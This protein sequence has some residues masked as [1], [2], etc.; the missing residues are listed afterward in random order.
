[1]RPVQA[2]EHDAVGA[3]T[4][5]VYRQAGWSYPDYEPHLR[6]ATSRAQTA[7]VLVALAGQR[8]T[9]AVTV[10]T[11]LGP[12][13]EQAVRGEAI[14][15]MLVVAPDQRGAGIGEA[16]VR[17]T[18]E[19]ARA[20]GCAMVRLSSRPDMTAAHRLYERLGFTRTP[21]FDWTPH[22]GVQ[23]LGYALALVPWCARCGEGLTPDGH[24]RCRDA[25]ELEPPR[26]CA[27]CRRR[28][29]VQVTPSGWTARCVE[30]GTTTS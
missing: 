1:M 24:Q 10:A 15:R 23:L 19:V 13:A 25:V 18:V 16:L 5:E 14:V 7:S 22:D 27:H 30:H 20:D 26:Y 4:V 3:L 6:D 21:S 28:H 2:R 29:V 9:G 17:A 8:V 12:W 11:R